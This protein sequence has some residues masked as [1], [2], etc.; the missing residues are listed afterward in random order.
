[1][2]I[3]SLL[4]GVP[5]K[6]T[7]VV[8]VGGVLKREEMD[9]VM[10]PHD[11]KAIEAADFVKRRIGG[12]TIALSMGP[13]IKLAPLVQPLHEPRHPSAARLQE[14]EPHA[15]ETVQHAAADERGHGPLLFQR[16]LHAVQEE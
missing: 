12:K 1:M 4:K 7:K 11:M 14:A 16:V 15:G 5:A 3:I 8:T 9:I 2:L 13:D 6:T 10:N